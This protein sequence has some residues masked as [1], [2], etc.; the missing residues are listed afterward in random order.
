[1]PLLYYAIKVVMVVAGGVL[2]WLVGGAIARV[3]VRLA[4]QRRAPG[5]AVTAGKIGSAVLFGFLAY[6]IPI[7]G[8]GGTG[9]FGGTGN[10][11]AGANKDS[12][13]KAGDKVS[14]DSTSKNEADSVLAVYMLGGDAI[15]GKRF[16]QVSSDGQKKA[17]TRDDLRKIIAKD[18]ARYTRLDIH[19]DSYSVA[20]PDDQVFIAPEDRSDPYRQ[21][22][23]LAQ[24]FKLKTRLIKDPRPGGNKV[25]D[26]K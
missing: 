16:Y 26:N 8:G 18:P 12:S 13:G 25:P 23:D 15:V 6:L 24:E 20:P 10:D 1:V 14:R 2:G 4:F 5:T 11:K 22:E 17:L 21:L 3:L 19:W 7:G 9:L